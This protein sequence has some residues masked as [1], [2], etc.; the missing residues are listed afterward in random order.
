MSRPRFERRKTEDPGQDPHWQDITFPT[1]WPRLR[2]VPH[3]RDPHTASLRLARPPPGSDW[4]VD[5][6]TRRE[7]EARALSLRRV[8]ERLPAPCKYTSWRSCKQPVPTRVLCR[9][10]RPR[11]H[12][13]NIISNSTTRKLSPRNSSTPYD[14]LKRRLRPKRGGLIKYSG[15]LEQQQ[16]T[17]KRCQVSWGEQPRPATRRLPRPSSATPLQCILTDNDAR[18]DISATKHCTSFFTSTFCPSPC[19]Y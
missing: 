1:S 11:N 13:I 8:G 3:M 6:D 18:R 15:K 9:Y 2:P 17:R 19:D 5:H 4:C 14:E 12:P 16:T 10:V 7:P